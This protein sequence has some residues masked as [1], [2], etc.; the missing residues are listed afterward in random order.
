[1]RSD[2]PMAVSTLELSTSAKTAA[3]HIESI[4]EQ[5]YKNTSLENQYKN[6]ILTLFQ[7]LLTLIHDF[8]ALVE[9]NNDLK[10]ALI[11]TLEISE[12]S[13]WAAQKLTEIE[14]LEE[15]DLLIK[16]ALWLSIHAAIDTVFLAEDNALK[17]QKLF[18]HKKVFSGLEIA[19]FPMT[20]T[21]IA[22]HGLTINCE[23]YIRALLILND[24]ISTKKDE[25]KKSF[26]QGFGEPQEKSGTLQE[27]Q[28]LSGKVVDLL[29]LALT[30]NQKKDE[31]SIV[32]LTGISWTSY[33][34]LSDSMAD[35]SWCRISYAN[36]NLELLVPTRKH[37]KIYRKLDLLISKYCDEYEIPFCPLGC[38]RFKTKN[39]GKEPDSCYTIGVDCSADLER[40]IPDL[41]IEV[42]WTSGSIRDLKDK[43]QPLGVPE[44]WIWDKKHNLRFYALEQDGYI[45]ISRSQQLDKITPQLMQKYLSLM[46]IRDNVIVK[47]EFIS[48]LKGEICG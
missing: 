32:H 15:R 24:S 7:E 27:I 36:R 11:K 25:I 20:L 16:S 39:I 6:E 21:F 42:N 18:Y 2:K 1:M 48:E 13:L 45:E 29:N 22:D 28:K 12:K 9:K 26:K 46:D 44:V 43:Y 17:S 33:E 30:I 38:T 31:D 14:F 41:A 34:N 35:E 4:L 40:D 5:L 47:K 3:P 23:R 8:N 19:Q 37:E 10:I